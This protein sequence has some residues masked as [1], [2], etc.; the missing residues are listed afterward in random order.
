MNVANQNNPDKNFYT[1]QNR[2]IHKARTQLGMSLD[3]C[4]QLAKQIGGKPS[5]SSLTLIERWELIEEMK[6]KGARVFNPALPAKSVSYPTQRPKKRPKDVYPL[7][8]AEWRKKFPSKRPGFASNKQL[9][10][11][12]AIWELD[13]N[14]GRAGSSAKGLRGFIYRQTKNLEYG[15]VS[16]LAFLRSGHVAAVMMP[17]RAKAREKINQQTKGGSVKN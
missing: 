8:L 13:F 16:D 9:A 7:Y 11:I 1:C 2:K 3:E 6:M 10:W 17:L 12:Q 4:R 5:I 15:P 14:D